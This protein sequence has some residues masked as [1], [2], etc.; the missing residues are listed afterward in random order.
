M[1]SKSE[2][3]IENLKLNPCISSAQ[4]YVAGTSIEEIRRKYGLE[5][6]IKL[7]S[8]ENALGP[9]PLAVEAV[10]K[11]LA[12]VHRYPPM[13]D[14]ELRAKL[15]STLSDSGLSEECF[16]TGNGSCDVLA[17]VTR[18]FIYEE[19]DEAIL[20][21]PTFVMY[22]ISV[23]ICGGKCVFVNLK[24]DFSYDLPQVLASITDR[25][26][27]I[28][29]CNPN[30]PTGTMIARDELDD[31]LNR[32]PSSVLV[33]IDEAYWEYADPEL[34]PDT[35]AYVREGRNVLVTR[36]F[37]KVYGLAGLRIGYGIACEELAQYIRR[38]RLPFHINTVAM[39]GAIA[40]LDDQEHVKKSVRH[41]RAEREFLYA[42]LDDLELPYARSQTNFIIVKPGY[43]PQLIYERM[44]EKGVIIRPMAA[45]RAPDCFR[46]T[47]GTRAENEHLLQVLGEVM[48][49]LRQGS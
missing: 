14:D 47:V 21:P 45:F 19:G 42:G 40:A 26:R 37:A 24:D 22:E 44:L 13:S 12:G 33:V 34:L 41:N 38:L 30:N 16:I 17:M 6:I 1:K 4:L 28:F 2:K 11:T 43:D 35:L 7:A 49:G 20:C 8:N 39:R 31:F 15:A 18:A 3:P 10:Q 29:L 36:T 46:I 9:S 32:V 48:D 27:L 25:T 23:N 5:E